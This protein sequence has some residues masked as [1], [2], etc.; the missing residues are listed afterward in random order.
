MSLGANQSLVKLAGTLRPAEQQVSMPLVSFFG[1]STLSSARPSL[2]LTYSLF[3]RFII[4]LVNSHPLLIDYTMTHGHLPL[5]LGTGNGTPSSARIPMPEAPHPP[6]LP[7]SPLNMQ[8]HQAAVE[9]C[10]Y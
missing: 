5:V 6:A 4:I 8:Q 1:M 7:P 2:I 10:R 9:N 3:Y